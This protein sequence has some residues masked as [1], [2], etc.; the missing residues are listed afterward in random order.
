MYILGLKE[1]NKQICR[2]KGGILD[3]LNGHMYDWGRIKGF[4]MVKEGDGIWENLR[5]E[6][7]GSWEQQATR[8]A[9][10]GIKGQYTNFLIWGSE[11]EVVTFKI[12]C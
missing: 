3:S 10:I 6:A 9:Q 1:G 8:G 7:F 5:N 11:F 2:C 4:F 12:L